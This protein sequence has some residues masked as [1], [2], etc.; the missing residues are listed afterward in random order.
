M[1][2]YLNQYKSKLTFISDRQKGLI[3][4]IADVFPNVIHRDKPVHRALEKLNLVLMKLMYERRLKAREWDQ[5]GLLSRAKKH[6]AKMETFYGHYHPEGV[7][8]GCFIAITVNG[9]RWRVNTEK[10]ECDCNEWQL[11]GLPCVYAVSI[12]LPFRE[13]WI[14]Y[15]SPYHRVSSYVAT[16]RKAIYPMVDSSAWKKPPITPNLS[17]RGRSVGRSANRARGRNGANVHYNNYGGTIG[18]GI[19]LFGDSVVVRGRAS[20]G[21]AGRN[22]GG[23]RGGGASGGG[24]TGRDEASGGGVA[25]RG[26]ARGGRAGRNVGGTRGGGASDGGTRPNFNPP[27]QVLAQSQPSTS[28]P[29]KKNFQPPNRTW[30]P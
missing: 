5:D 27:R 26:G 23:T 21:R 24:A 15:C 29:Y 9:Q 2:P 6:I 13:S 17:E 10:H 1:K 28:N 3:Q 25:V 7:V 12:L 14:E 18:I 4:A 30:K 11:T 19:D 20:C 16:Y 22:V 8:D